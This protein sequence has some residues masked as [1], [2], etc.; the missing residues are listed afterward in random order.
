MKLSALL[1][2][3]FNVSIDQDREINGL[4]LHSKQVEPGDVFIA[5]KGS[6]HHGDHYIEEAIA[7]G[8]VAA[9]IETECDFSTQQFP[10]PVIAVQDLK[11]RLENF[12]QKFY[13]NCYQG[14]KIIGV[15]GTNGKTTIAYLIHQ[16]L[17]RL[18]NVA[19]FIGTIGYGINY[20][21]QSS[22]WTTPDSLS[23]KKYICKLKEQHANYIA[24]EIS[25]HGLAQNRVHDLPV[26]TAIFSNLTHEHLDYH[27][28]MEA[29]FEA[30]SKLFH[31]N[32]LQCA[33]INVDSDYAKKM[34]AQV[35]R[36]VN[37]ILYSLQPQIEPS[38]L[39]RPN[40]DWIVVK[41]SQLSANGTQAYIESSFGKGSLQTILLG[42]FNLNNCLAV[43]AALCH[44]GYSLDNAL[45][46]LRFVKPPPGRME[47]LG[48]SD[49]PKFIIDY[50]HTPDALENALKAARQHCERQLWCVFGCGGNRD[51]T[52]RG[53]MGHIASIYADKV[54]ITN[55]NPRFEIPEKIIEDIV[56]G[57]SCDVANKISI[58]PDRKKA[59]ECAFQRALPLDTVLVAGKGH[60][61]YQIIKDKKI[62]LSDYDCINN[63]IREY[64][65]Q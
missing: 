3:H 48:N 65:L 20:N 35:G 19:G 7:K 23:L 39:R 28:T 55:D 51:A 22:D 47:L 17:N 64:T 18:G 9:L 44:Q 24:M 25:S 53:K 15:T 11:L 31:F 14:L 6:Q 59:I 38:L 21:L 61:D 50:A 4:C 62:R 2:D 41:S 63:L 42:S 56:A 1:Q 5:L 33:I 13:H 60:E 40:T 37:L 54:I 12:S 45:Q 58:E 57:I 29:Y 30:K 8:A 27:Q 16:A 26:E 36:Q 52:R 46:V 32:T 49:T 43:L 10:I 34:M